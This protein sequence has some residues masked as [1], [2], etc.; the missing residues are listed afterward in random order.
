MPMKPSPDIDADAPRR[1]LI[2]EDHPIFQMGLVDLIQQEADLTVCGAVADVGDACR[3]IASLHPDLVIVDLSLKQSNG[4]DLL[5]TIKAE[6]KS[7]PV[8]V[9]SMHDEQ[10]HAE[11]CLRAGARGY[12]NKKETSESV[13]TAIRHLLGGNIFLS[14]SMTAAILNKFQKN[15]AKLA[16][17]PLGCLTSRELEVFYLIGR[18]KTPAEIA[19]RLHLSVKTIG[20]HKERIKEKLGMKNAAELVRYAVLWV[21]KEGA[22][23]TLA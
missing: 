7:L 11:R 21:E 16:G 1:I 13:I 12:I 2:V 22:Q 19:D 14:T 10:I 20:T 9:L 15:P 8:L 17:S 4:F 5:Q 6:H 23:G 3:A 18:G